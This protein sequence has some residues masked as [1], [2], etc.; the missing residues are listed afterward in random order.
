MLKLGL[1]DPKLVRNVKRL[2]EQNISQDFQFFFTVLT[3]S[4]FLVRWVCK[5]TWC[6]P[7]VRVILT[8]YWPRC[9][10][11]F[12]NVPHIMNMLYSISILY[13]RYAKAQ[14]IVFNSSVNFKA[15]HDCSFAIP[16]RELYF[17]PD[18]LLLLFTIVRF[19]IISFE[20]KVKKEKEN[21][22][23]T[24]SHEGQ[25]GEI[26]RC[27]VSNQSQILQFILTCKL[28]W[29][30][31]EIMTLWLSHSMPHATCMFSQQSTV[32]NIA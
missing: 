19:E 2:E 20:R 12:R 25:S 17:S 8:H 27:V 28:E 6:L 16:K 3:V 23:Q 7:L 10:E 4:R 5:K 14:I 9:S 21:K 30:L 32:F 11:L 24:T 18:W 15:M 22:Q 26:I 31:K 13:D 1:I 29:Q